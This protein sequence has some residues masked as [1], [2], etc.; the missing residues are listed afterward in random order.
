ME[1][2]KSKYDGP[3]FVVYAILPNG[4][5]ICVDTCEFRDQAREIKERAEN[6]WP[7]AEVIICDY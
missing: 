6:R 4:N 1:N 3:N 2:W 7:D 5:E